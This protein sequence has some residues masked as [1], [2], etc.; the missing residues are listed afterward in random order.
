MNKAKLESLSLS[1]WSLANLAI[2]HN[3]VADGMNMQGV[4]D[5]FSIYANWIADDPSC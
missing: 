2:F 5:Y 1:Q 4:L 3:H